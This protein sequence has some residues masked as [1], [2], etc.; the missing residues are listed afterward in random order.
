MT[1]EHAV[2]HMAVERAGEGAWRVTDASGRSTVVHVA[3]SREGCWAHVDGDVFVFEAGRDPGRPRAAAAPDASLSAPMPATVIAIVAP[4]G[5]SVEE[6]D[7]LLLLE[8]MKME[9]PVRAPRAGTVAAVHCRE[10]ELVQAGVTLVD[11]A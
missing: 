10:G 7:V 2:R 3:L 11:L 6:G 9:L 8:A 1:D 4:A 5:T